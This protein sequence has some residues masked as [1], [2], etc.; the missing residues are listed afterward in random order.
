MTDSKEAKGQRLGPLDE[1]ELIA[2]GTRY[3]IKG[4]GF[5]PT[6]SFKD[7]AGGPGH[8]SRVLMLQLLFLVLFTVI[9]VV[10]LV[11]VS[12]VPSYQEQ[13]QAKQMI[14]NKMNQL[15][16]GIGRLC[17]PCSWDWTLFQRNCY[18]FSNSKLNWSNSVTACQEMRAQLV[19]IKSVEEQNFLQ[20]SSKNRGPTWM[21][22]SDLKKEGV[23]HWLDGS[24]LWF[25]FTKYWLPG[26]PNND[27]K[28]DCAEFRGD[29]WNDGKCE[30]EK[31]W[32]CKKPAASCS[33]I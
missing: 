26:E 30:R 20:L 11:K 27:G 28:E 9:L 33:N 25:R 12:K 7:I 8:G 17:R 10:V 24:H 1:E 32:I 23:W 22:L 4:L 15:K 16:N 18:F 3:F 13:K 31:F 21:G 14:N 2:G 29:G 5:R 6:Y 19:V